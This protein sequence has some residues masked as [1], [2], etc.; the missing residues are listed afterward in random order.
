MR[1]NRQTDMAKLI[2]AFRNFAKAPKKLPPPRE[3]ERERADCAVLLQ[4]A[5]WRQAAPSVTQ[6][7]EA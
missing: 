6:K 3:R 2:V 1:T 7:E 4:Q 5:A